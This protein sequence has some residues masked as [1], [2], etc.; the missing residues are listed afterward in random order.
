MTQSRLATDPAGAGGRLRPPSAGPLPDR[1]IGLAEA[2]PDATAYLFH[3]PSGAPESLC[4]RDLAARA[5]EAARRLRAAGCARGDRVALV[6]GH[7]PSFVIALFGAFLAGCA[8]VPVAPPTGGT[9][10]AR[11]GAI[12]DEAGCAA[13][14]TD[15]DLRESLD[16]EVSALAARPTVLCLNDPPSGEPGIPIVTGPDDVA[17]VQYTSGSTNRPRGVVVTHAALVAQMR[18]IL[19]AAGDA[20]GDR[21]VTWL[22]PEHDMGLVGGLLFNLWRGG[23]TYVLSPESFIR[24]PFLWL[25]TISRWRATMSVAPNFAYDL[26]VRGIPPERR[27]TLDLSGWRV[28]LNGAEPVRHD[29]LQRFNEAFAAAGFDPLAWLPCYGLAEATLLVS[30]ATRGTGARSGWFDADAL[31]TGRVVPTATGIGRCLVSSGAVRTTGGVRIVAPDSAVPCA[32]DRVGEIWIAGD[33]LGSGYH[34]RPDESRQT[35]GATDASGGGPWLRSGD[36]GFLWEGELYVTGR[37]K[38]IVLWHGRTLHAFDLENAL[39]DADPAIRPGR[40]AAHQRDGGDV[41]LVVEIAQGRLGPDGGT[42]LAERIWRLLLSRS[43]VEAARVRL[44]RPGTLMWTSSGKLRRRDSHAALEE[45]PA[46]LIL[47][48]RPGSLRARRAQL[49]ATET[50]AAAVARNGADSRTYLRF[51]TQW[52]AAALDCAGDDIDTALSWADQGLDSLMVT[53]LVADLERATGRAIAPET[54]FDI[55]DPQRLAASLAEGTA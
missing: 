23:P 14:L 25:D 6:F 51:F 20:G 4:F 17:I 5:T 8:A 37:I 16:R 12:L 48:W 30:G 43:G 42:A 47:D 41:G 40:I 52:I 55:P 13:L 39:S 7:G 21:V 2:R 36:T 22:P 3:R 31:E 26:C 53:E 27:A 33:S 38:D 50:L 35:F 19:A 54:L 44:A 18:T 34:G 10:R 24:R 28:A 45:N 46:Q 15:P 29:T 9:K 1:L 11:V 49:A 32:P